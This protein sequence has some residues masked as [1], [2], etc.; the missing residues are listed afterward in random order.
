VKRLIALLLC[1][2]LTIPAFAFAE[3]EK[4]VNIL[5]WE[6]YIDADTIAAFEAETGIKV[7]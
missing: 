7:I 2:I 3:E 4:V 5:S 1:L 6:G